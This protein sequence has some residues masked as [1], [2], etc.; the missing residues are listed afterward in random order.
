[1]IGGRKSIVFPFL[2]MF[3]FLV[4]SLL[5]AGTWDAQVNNALQRSSYSQQEKHQVQTLFTQAED[6][7]APVELLIN[8]L[9]EGVAKQVPAQLL[10]NALQQ[11]LESFTAAKN[12]VSTYLNKREAERIIA[13]TAVWSR[14]ATLYRQGISQHD[15]GE[16]IKVFNKQTV[17]EKW[18][19]F[20]Y[21]GGLLIALRQWGV[22]PESSLAV[23]KA[24]ALSSIAGD[25]YRRVIDLFNSA[26]ANRISSDAMAQRI[27]EAAPR[28]RTMSILERQVR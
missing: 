28:S 3:W 2:I 21:G 6:Q 23:V 22:T 18:N 20:R 19:N 11:E 5:P 24:L 27:I 8:R 14:I 13:D 26:L 4:G 7:Q 10:Q 12:I 15:L 25:E 9:D 17:K 16:L 1:M